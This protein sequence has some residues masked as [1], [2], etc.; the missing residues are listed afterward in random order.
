MRGHTILAA[1]L[2]VFTG[3]SG[4][5]VPQRDVARG[6]GI[7][8]LDGPYRVALVPGRVGNT[9]GLVAT[10]LEQTDDGDEVI[11]AT[12][13]EKHVIDGQVASRASKTYGYQFKGDDLLS[14]DVA[15]EEPWRVD[16]ALRID[17]RYHEA[18]GIELRR[19]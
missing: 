11:C 7:F 10:A 9:V 12:I 14:V 1:V 16:V 19:P 5:D 3:C 8:D 18:E 4:G 17:G 2:A 15:F 13:V 6:G